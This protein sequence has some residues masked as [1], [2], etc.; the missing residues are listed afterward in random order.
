MTPSLVGIRIASMSSGKSKI[1]KLKAILLTIVALG[2]AGLFILASWTI[3]LNQVINQALQERTLTPTQEF[4]AL[5]NQVFLGQNIRIESLLSDLEVYRLKLS[6]TGVL[7]DGE[8]R[9]LKKEQCQARLPNIDKDFVHCLELRFRKNFV[10]NS[11]SHLLIA[12]ENA[13][14]INH[15]E[16]LNN[17]EE[18]IVADFPPIRFAQYIGDKSI[19]RRNMELGEFPAICLNAVLAIEDPRFLEHQGF[20][21]RSI[22]RAIIKNIQAG[23]K[24]QGGSTITQQLVKNYFLTHQKTY[25]RKL[26]ELIMA[27]LLE[28]RSSK[29]NILQAYLNEIY[30]AQNGV[31]E[32]RGFAAASEHYF[33]KEVEKINTAECALLAAIL[34]SPGRY[35]PFKNPDNAKARRSLVLSKLKEEGIL[36]DNEFEKWDNYPLPSNQ[37]VVRLDPAPYFLDA[38]R[39]ELQEL[40]IDSGKNLKVITSLNLNAQ[41]AARKALKNGLNN[42]E[43]WRKNLKK[44]VEEGKKLQG[45]ILSV[46][47]LNSYVSSMV[48]GRDYRTAPF[49]RALRAKRQVGS[50]MKPFVYLSALESFRPETNE[51]YTPITELPDE[52]I[53]Y[54]YDNQSWT[55]RN[56][57]KKFRG[58]VPLYYALKNS[59]NAPTANLGIESGLDNIVDV[60][61]R[62]G[63]RSK[64]FPYP[65]LTL[66]AYELHPVEVLQAYAALAR[67]GEIRDLKFV[68]QAYDSENQ[69]IYKAENN[70]K[71]VIAKENAAVLVGMLKQTIET[72]SGQVVRKLGFERPAAGKTGTT[73]D[74]HDSWFAGFTPYHAAI[75]W[76]GYD[77]NTPHGLTGASGAAPIW[78]NYMK[79]IQHLLPDRDFSWP[80]GVSVVDLYPSD[81]STNEELKQ[82]EEFNQ[83]VQLIFRKGNEP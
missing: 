10:E 4:F 39:D 42:L 43:K 73:S 2:L 66:G 78:A 71:Q 79:S 18:E 69:M 22:G 13:D 25:T 77:D 1:K 60:A 9:L 40:K 47:P 81:Y 46:D 82:S 72:G 45:A 17:Q 54:D 12:W 68:V 24:A 44:N 41:A 76:V 65:S 14:T 23:R 80:E 83:K 67:F 36:N 74:Y 37:S 55:P 51:F 75:V 70:P 59:L 52:K 63:V 62:L 35:N 57:D 33:A 38:V 15:I 5:G 56:Y 49:N 53:T 30:M 3:H 16:N 50:I 28:I 6:K 26:K 20:S 27:V 7:L 8:L 61:Y 19:L 29:D 32:V 58:K 48:G 11:Q 31:F 21:F 64:L 34:N